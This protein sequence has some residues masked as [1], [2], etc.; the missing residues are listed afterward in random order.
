M[1][2]KTK[3][4]NIVETINDMIN[5]GREKGVLHHYAE[6]ESHNGRIIKVNGKELIH[7]GSCSY[8]GLDVDERLKEGAIGAIRKHGV[9]FSTS[10]TY[11]SSTLYTEF[12]N[13]L[14][15]LFGASII[16]TTTLS[17]GHHAVIPVVVEEGDA[18]IL[19]QQVHASIQEAALR[20]EAR[21]VPLTKIRHN[22]ME[23]LETKI[24]ELK[25]KHDRIWYMI[26]GVYSMYG[27]FPPLQYLVGLMEKHKQ[28]HLY[29]DD[30]HGMSIA[31]KHGRGLALSRITL[32]PKMIM[33]TSLNK[34]FA[35]GGGVFI[36]PNAEICK[37]VM[38]CG[39]P[40][41]FSGPLPTATI[42][43]GIA[44]AKIHLSDEIIQRQ[45]ALR[46]K[47]RYCHEL[48]LEKKL[49]VVSH[50]EAPINFIGLGLIKVGVNMVNRIINDG[51]Y[52]NLAMFPA[53]PD[54]CTG[55]R[56]TITLHH[57]EEDI[58][59]LVKKLAY[60][61]PKALREEGR[62][63]A[64]VQRAFR[65]VSN[66]ETG[67]PDLPETESP[68]FFPTSAE[69]TL[70]HETTIQNIDKETWNNLMGSKGA[71]DWHELLFFEETFSGHDLPE[72]NWNFHYY[73]IRDKENI[74]VLA[75]FFTATIA[76]DDMFSPAAVS[77]QLELL[78]KNNPYYLSSTIF[79]M[80]CLLSVG[81]H[82]YIDRSHKDWKKIM[83]LLLDEVWK[84]Q[85]RQ[86]ATVLSLRDFAAEDQVTHDFFLEQSF[87]KI[88][89]PDGH[90]IDY[91]TW[92]S[93]D[94]L[95]NCLKGDKRHY[96]R[97]KVLDF[98]NRYETRLVGYATEAELE[99]YYHLYNNVSDKSFEI[100]G[101]NLNRKFF[102]NAVKH[103][104][105]ELIELKLKPEY[106]QRP[107]RK[108][109]GIAI[110][111]RTKDNYCF[112]VT[113]LDYTY[114]EEHHVY[115]QT[116]WQT[117][118]RAKQLHSKTINLGLTASQNKRKFGTKV[119]KNVA[120]IQ[121]KDNFNADLVSLI[122]NK[123]MSI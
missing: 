37:K 96:M 91:L 67:P 38:N 86:K 10:R 107:E 15:E 44:S 50:P 103:P 55:L 78:R 34:A 120:Y 23:E 20:M 94:S 2:T 54:I 49:P 83:M 19:D 43:A 32:H 51:F 118:L 116:L 110:S 11:I 114:L 109:V 13:L 101:F 16:L 100:I 42:G 39:G 92:D 27:D 84:E 59:K 95:L 74:P 53:V 81:E 30:A 47:L 26:D 21:G 61:Y 17:L 72:H 1:G 102:E 112:L 63:F 108:A 12:E 62:T 40:L 28:F 105:W 111:Y 93:V 31:G 14:R 60:H 90:V 97:K 65:K 80:G 82:I 29:V 25:V 117:I 85:D 119:L 123:E 41:I 6:G 79:T 77:K 66:F 99:H 46:E 45:A 48:L 106:D 7:F 52:V 18:L 22:N 56:F 68:A 24:N 104:Q 33:A 64:D 76:K 87:I 57:T 35:G 121:V 71:N 88:D 69:Y 36:F 3:T 9:H 115:A 58:D 75:T 5:F 113:G 4:A 70:Q 73:I 89:L 122:A 8:M 98:E